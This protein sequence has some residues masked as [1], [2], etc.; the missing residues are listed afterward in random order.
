MLSHRVMNAN[1]H[2]VTQ[3]HARVR[4][5]AGTWRLRF[6]SFVVG[7]K[8]WTG[9]GHVSHPELPTTPVG[10]VLCTS[11]LALNGRH[12]VEVPWPSFAHHAH[13]HV[14]TIPSVP[15]VYC[16]AC[17][18]QALARTSYPLPLVGHPSFST[19]SPRGGG[20]RQ[21]QHPRP[22][23]RRCPRSP[24]LLPRQWTWV[25]VGP[26]SR[27]VVAAANPIAAAVA[28]AFVAVPVS[29]MLVSI[30][31]CARPHEEAPSLR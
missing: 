11:E 13:C 19:W 5:R 18:V 7:L 14:H 15:S 24:Y 30:T 29:V 25:R 8:K 20:A 26:L 22:R 23:P 28:I 10:R 2:A 31:V 21:Q 3:G 9:F 4:T 12:C 6:F 16:A 1:T 17:H 27:C